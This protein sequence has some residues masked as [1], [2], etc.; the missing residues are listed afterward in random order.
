MLSIL[1]FS[2]IVLIAS[3]FFGAHALL[4]DGLNFR[5]PFTSD[6]FKA[7]DPD[8]AG[9]IRITP[10]ESTVSG[11][12]IDNQKAGELFVITGRVRNDYDHPRSN[13]RVL[14]S[15]CISEVRRVCIN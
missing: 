11:K 12:F 4:P 10:L 15:T 8:P 13:I 5:I 6:P 9:N 1:L 2:L 14:E 7:K 3:I